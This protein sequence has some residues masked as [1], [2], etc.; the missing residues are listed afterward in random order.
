MSPGQNLV[1]QALRAPDDTTSW[2]GSVWSLAVQQ[3]R[4]AGLLARLAHQLQERGLQPP[5]P[6]GVAGHF[7]SAL[8][9]SRA[10]QAEIRRELVFVLGAL[11]GLPAPVVLL[12]GA[13]Y[14]MAELPAARGRVFGDID[15]LVPKAALAQT[16]TQLML[17]GWMSSHQSAYDQR[18]YRQWMQELPPLQNVH[19]GTVLDVHHAILPETARVRPEPSKLFERIVPVAGHAGLFV[20]APE[21]MVLHSMTHLFFNDDT[22]YALRDLSDLDLLLR[23][24]AQ[25]ADFWSQLI[26]RAAALNLTRPLYY[27]LRQTA[28]LLGTPVPASALQETQAFAPALPTAALMDAIWQRALRSRHPSAAT[29]GTWAALS[30]L[31]LRGHWLRMPPFMLA[32]H[33]TIKALHL[34][35]KES[36]DRAKAAI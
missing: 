36:P 13:A 3:A 2:N 17:G 16:E 9:V 28:R 20:L 30:A 35:E 25:H 6:A 34:Y 7:D 4:K 8:R 18:Y 31:Y 1:A 15:I 26:T 27:G 5:G 11:A 29:A 22:S 19:R 24:F 32:R 10:Q 23:H 12:K 14:V 33:L 21:D